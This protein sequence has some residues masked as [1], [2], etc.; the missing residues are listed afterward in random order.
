MTNYPR[1]HKS[2]TDIAVSRSLMLDTEPERIL[3]MDTFTRI[4]R[5]AVG[6]INSPMDAEL[7][8]FAASTR[9]SVMEAAMIE[10]LASLRAEGIRL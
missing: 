1:D 7:L 9:G 2:P 5:L 10:A 8:Y 4:R 3:F 6:L